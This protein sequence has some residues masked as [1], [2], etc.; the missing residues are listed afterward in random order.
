VA[1]NT[2]NPD[3]AATS[4]ARAERVLARCEVLARHSIEPGQIT[5]PYG[6]PALRDAGNDIASWMRATGMSVHCDAIGNVRG[7]IAGSLEEAPA[8]LLGSHFDSVRDAGRYDGILGILVGIAAVER[9]AAEQHRLP[10]PLEVVAFPDEEGLR[11]QTT[12][13]GSSAMA[14]VF[15]PALLDFVD[16]DGITLRAAIT[17]CG[18]DPDGLQT[19]ALHPDE[20]FAYVEVHIEQGP[21]LES[22]DAPLGVVTAISGQTRIQAAFTG[23]AGHAGTV[24]MSLRRDPLPA[25]AQLILDAESLALRTPGLLATVGKAATAPGA[26]NVIPGRVEFSLDV[27]HPDDSLR[28]AAVGDLEGRGHGLAAERS[29]RFDWSVLRDHPAVRCDFGLANRLG[30]AVTAAGLADVRLP[31]GAG[32]DAAIMSTRLPVAMLFVRCAGG[33]SHHPAESVR[34]DDVAAAIDVIDRFLD[35]LASEPL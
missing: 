34:L 11:F 26:S 33:I 5:R 13:L 35:L 23:E 8:L 22:I 10:F 30:Q 12:Y 24:A 19:A 31:S 2:P 1:A 21:Y 7:H 6:T 15:D 20:A 28:L 25:A 9:L 14:G 27:R 29:L 16:A 32:H 17:E 18:G 4:L 3:I